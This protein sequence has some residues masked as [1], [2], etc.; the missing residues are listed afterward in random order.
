MA[1]CKLSECE[2]EFTSPKAWAEFCCEQ[3]RQ[4]WHYL[5]R[6]AA[7]NMA[8]EIEVAHPEATLPN[9]LVVGHSP[10]VELP[11]KPLPS[12]EELGLVG[13]KPIVHRRKLVA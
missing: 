1:L 4:R 10:M 9:G 12:L 8:Y 6:K 3:H 13:P 11:P 5:Q 7:R 2:K